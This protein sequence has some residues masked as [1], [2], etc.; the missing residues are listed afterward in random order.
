MT[1]AKDYLVEKGYDRTVWGRRIIAA[2]ER[3]HFTLKD[4]QEAIKWHHCACGNLDEHPAIKKAFNNKPEDIAL[5][6][7]GARFSGSVRFDNLEN[8]ANL[9]VKINK[10]AVELIAEW[11]RRQ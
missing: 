5:R 3:G 1:P 9:L 4:N 2:E 7:Y 11:E 10:R 6:A 8:A